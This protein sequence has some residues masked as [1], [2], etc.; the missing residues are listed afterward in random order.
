[1]NHLAFSCVSGDVAV[2]EFSCSSLS[3]EVVS[4]NLEIGCTVD[5]TAEFQVISGGIRFTGSC[6]EFESSQTSGDLD[7][8]GSAEKLTASTVSGDVTAEG[9]CGEMQVEAASGDIYIKAADPSVT[10]TGR[11]IVIDGGGCRQREVC[12]GGIGQRPESDE[13]F[14]GNLDRYILMGSLSECGDLLFRTPWRAPERGMIK[15]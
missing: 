12:P 5:G 9:A 14:R 2:P 3:V 1:M 10:A 6:Q 15:V 8:L 4:G 11:E 13:S 7:F